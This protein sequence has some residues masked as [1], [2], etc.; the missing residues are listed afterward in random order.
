MKE[1]QAL[2]R[3]DRIARVVAMLCEGLP[4][5]T[6]SPMTYCAYEAGLDD[7]DTDE[8]ERAGLRA[9]KVC[10]FVPS[11]A[12]LRELCGCLTTEQRMVKAWEILGAA[13]RKWAYYYSIV[14]DDP[15]L[16]ATV[17]NFGGWIA[18]SERWSDTPVPTWDAFF[19]KDFERVYA[20]FV[21]SGF[22]G[23]AGTTP[24]IGWFDKSNRTARKSSR[25]YLVEYE[26]GL[27]ALTHSPA[28]RLQPRRIAKHRSTEE[29][30][31]LTAGAGAV[32]GR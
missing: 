25:D 14:F 19:R 30:D 15:A 10:K 11:V 24:L 20:A 22:W 7:L 8:V 4:G 23:E 1:T 18:L 16:N 2:S 13:L 6:A 29:R 21:S 27:P 9:L 32:G 26:T 31:P 28:A 17:H 3:T 12:E 5:K